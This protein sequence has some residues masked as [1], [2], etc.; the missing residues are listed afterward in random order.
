MHSPLNCN[1][2]CR[3]CICFDHIVFEFDLIKCCHGWRMDECVAKWIKSSKHSIPSSS[4][5]IKTNPF[6]LKEHL[7]GLC[8]T[9]H[10]ALFK[11]FFTLYKNQ[12][13]CALL[14]ELLCSD[15]HSSL[16]AHMSKLTLVRTAVKTKHLLTRSDKSFV[17]F[18]YK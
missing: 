13:L 8:Q 12:W 1:T 5:K 18:L 3:Q 2:L 16:D 17:C 7:N 14:H 4:T 15:E 11:V 10:A 9:C 6:S